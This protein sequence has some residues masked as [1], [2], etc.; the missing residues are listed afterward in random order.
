MKTNIKK[1]NETMRFFNDGATTVAQQ[2]KVNVSL[3]EV[4]EVENDCNKKKVFEE[5]EK[6]FFST[7]FD[8]AEV[9]VQAEKAVT[10]GLLEQ[11][12]IENFVAMKKKQFKK[13]NAKT[14]EIENNLSY[15]AFCEKLQQNENL[16]K[17]VLSVIAVDTLPENIVISGKIQIFHIASEKSE[18]QKGEIVK[19]ENGRKFCENY[20]FE[21]VEINTEN[22]LASLKSYRLYQ[23]AQKRLLNKIQDSKKCLTRL[24]EIVKTCKEC[25][26]TNEEIL[27]V[28]NANL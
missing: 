25:N 6:Y 23:N 2:D 19:D 17:K 12:E 15:S 10:L 4:N 3:P 26:F 28:I 27:N 22:I 9:R 5:L 8:E 20:F 21:L 13:R 18:F 24:A 7:V 16:C 1:E 11:E 14:I